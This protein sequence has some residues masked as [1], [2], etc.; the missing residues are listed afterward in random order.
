MSARPGAAKRVLLL[1]PVYNDWDA[2][3]GL[4][5]QIA[6]LQTGPRLNL[7]ALLI[8]DGSDQAF[9]RA[10][11]TAT[12]RSSLRSLSVLRLARNLGHQGA[13]AVGLSHVAGLARRPDAVLVMDG[14][15]EDAPADILK[16]VDAWRGSGYKLAVFAQRTRRS[17]GLVFRTFYALYKMAYRVLTGT[18]IS[19]GNFSLLPAATVDQLTLYPELWRHYPAT[20]K[21]S[22]LPALLVD[23]ERATRFDGQSKMNF[24]RL[25]LHGLGAITV[26]SEIVGV[27]V[28]AAMAVLLLACLGC[29]ALVAGLWL[30][31]ST[32]VPAWAS[33]LFAYLTLVAL[34]FL[35]SALIFAFLT[36]AG[37]SPAALNP[38]Q[39]YQAFV[40]RRISVY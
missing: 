14:D 12:K 24:Y 36:V 10:R 37:H 18:G 40:Q 25:V 5:A 27:R 19:M 3:L 16:L 32:V 9:P 21:K 2:A 11:F 8:D 35:S 23:T 6:K 4:L 20:M 26:H 39:N 28:L 29:Q 34:Q 1:I 30:F 22:R 33:S 13:I 7:E 38:G 17:E 31:T 15:G